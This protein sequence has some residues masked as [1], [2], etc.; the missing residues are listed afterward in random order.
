MTDDD[1]VIRHTRRLVD[2]MR[3]ERERLAKQI[4]ESEQTI[5]RSRELIARIDRLLANIDRE[6]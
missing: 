6:T 1:V 2:E 3:G 5:E 4:R